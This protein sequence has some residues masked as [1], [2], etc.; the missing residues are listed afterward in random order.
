M[1]GFECLDLDYVKNLVESFED[2]E[3]EHESTETSQEQEDSRQ[4]I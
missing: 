3:R 1:T 4:S 2:E